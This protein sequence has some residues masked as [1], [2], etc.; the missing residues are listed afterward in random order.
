M[1]NRSNGAHRIEGT[2]DDL[3]RARPIDVVRG[4]G[5]EELGVGEER[6]ELI[7]QAMKQRLKVEVSRHVADAIDPL[8]DAH[9]CCPGAVRESD[10]WVRAGVAASRHRVSAKMRI[11]PP[12][13]R[14]YS[15]LPAEIQL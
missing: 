6:P 7:V 5:F 4:L 12:A 15:T 11:E 10:S 1:I 14:T 8:R 9:A 13:V 2:P 3:G